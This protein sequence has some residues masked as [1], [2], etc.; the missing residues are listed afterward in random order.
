MA[1]LDLVYSPTAIDVLCGTGQQERQHSGNIV[2]NRIVAQFS[3]AYNQATSKSEKMKIS[4]KIVELLTQSGV[5]FLKKCP[6]YQNWYVGG[7]RVGRDKI[8]HFLRLHRCQQQTAG[9]SAELLREAIAGT[10]S[11]LPQQRADLRQAMTIPKSPILPSVFS[12]PPPGA[13]R[14]ITSGAPSTSASMVVVAASRSFPDE[15]LSKTTSLSGAPSLL[16]EGKQRQ[17]GMTSGGEEESGSLVITKSTLNE[18]NDS[19][20]ASS[21]TGVQQIIPR[22]SID[23]SEG[24]MC[25]PMCRCK[26]MQG[27]SSVSWRMSVLSSLLTARIE[28]EEGP[29]AT[30]DTNKTDRSRAYY[31]MINKENKVAYTT[32]VNNVA[33]P[34]VA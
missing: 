31:N 20:A 6:I 33:R 27:L 34:S 18:D 7:P 30:P 13:P 2:F 5:R 21:T 26:K 32:M 24:S 9:G 28:Q 22:S 11:N 12:A 23:S 3:E 15:Q 29:T 10:A 14:I 8:G 16:E 4:K 17:G 25:L 19:S 1:D